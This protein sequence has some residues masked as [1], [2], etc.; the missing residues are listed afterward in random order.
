MLNSVLFFILQNPGEIFIILRDE[1]ISDAVEVEFVS[2]NKCIRIRP[3]PWNKT[4]WC[5]KALGKK[6]FYALIN[7][8]YH[9]EFLSINL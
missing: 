9:P 6:V 2:N 1:V 4:V 5:M 7:I 8:K 3:A